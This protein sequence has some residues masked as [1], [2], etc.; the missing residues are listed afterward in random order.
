MIFNGQ[1]KIINIYNLKLNFLVNGLDEDIKRFNSIHEEINYFSHHYK[2]AGDLSII[3]EKNAQIAEINGE[4]NVA[5]IWRNTFFI[6]E[7][8]KKFCSRLNFI[9]LISF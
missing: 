9:F 7:E 5:N 4:M 3:F 1:I 6:L 8:S 2:T